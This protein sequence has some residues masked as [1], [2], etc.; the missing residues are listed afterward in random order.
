MTWRSHNTAYACIYIH[1]HT[2]TQIHTFIQAVVPKFTG[3][4]INNIVLEKSHDKFVSALLM[5]TLMSVFFD[6]ICMYMYVYMYIYICIYRY[7]C[8]SKPH[9]KFVSALLML[10][11]MWVLFDF[12][13]VYMYILEHASL[14]SHQQLQACIHTHMHTCAYTA[15]T[16]R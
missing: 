5:L 1:T 7:L 12:M 4:V 13:Y 14:Q 10:R 8:V 15:H 3:D 16:C 9:D 6:F 11:L 2:H